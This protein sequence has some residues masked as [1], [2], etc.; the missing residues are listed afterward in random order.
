MAS[1]LLILNKPAGITSRQ[2]VDLVQRVAGQSKAGHAGTLDPLASGVLVV[3]LG[4]ATRLIEYVQQMPKGYEATFL[5][6]RSSPTD[7]IEGPV[8]ELPAAPLPTWEQLAEAARQ[9]TGLVSQR[10]PPYSAVKIEGRRAYDLARKGR[11]VE[12]APRPVQVYRL[13][14]LAYQYPELRLAVECGAGTY[15]RALGRD[16][17][18]TV[19]TQAVMS[20][21]VRTHI[22]PFH[23]SQAIPPE[24][25]DPAT[26]HQHM[27]PMARAVEHLPLVRVTAEE[28]RRL[29][30]GQPVPSRGTAA[31]APSAIWAALDVQGNLVAI[32]AAARP[33]R[34]VPVRTFTSE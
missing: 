8:T 18:R 1:G 30:Q 32:V 34:L 26:W 22:G 20:G 9:W 33:D 19:G 15:V 23:L 14:I 5:L 12:P 24:S 17:A 31:S 3:A 4:Q 13:E 11:R 16:L 2:A 25:L 29:R 6:G 21:L 10:P 7:D 28:A 27:L